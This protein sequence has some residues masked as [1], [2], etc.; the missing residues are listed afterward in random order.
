MTDDP[1]SQFSEA[2]AAAGYVPVKSKIEA[3]DKWH[4]CYINGEKKPHGAYAVKL[5]SNDFAIGQFKDRRS[6]EKTNWHSKTDKKLTAEDRKR[7][8]REQEASRLQR[9]QEDARKYA[10]VSARITKALRGLEKADKHPYLGRKL[11][12]AHG[13]KYRRKGNELIIP[14]Y[15]ADGKIYSVQRI[16]PNGAKFL[17]TGAKKTANY[18]P[19]ASA[20]DDKGIFLVC[21][22]FATGASLRE[23]TGLPVI[24]AF[25][26]GNMRPV[27]ETLK[28]KYP[29]SR[30]VI[31]ADNDAF[32]FDNKKKPEGIEAKEVGGDDPRWPVWAEE[33]RLYNTGIVKAKEAAVAI[34]GATVIWPQFTVS[35]ETKPTDFND[36]HALEGLDV[37]KERVL[38]A[39]PSA[40]GEAGKGEVLE[41]SAEP[42]QPPPPS[43]DYP[44]PEAP[45]SMEGYERDY[46]VEAL[47]EGDYG[48]RFKVLGYN[49]G[50]YYYF[51]YKARQIVALSASSHTLQNFLQLEDLDKWMDKFGAGGE[52]SEKKMALY[53]SNALMQ[54]AIKR[55]VFQEEDR[56]RGCGTWMDAGRVVLHCGDRLYVDG[57]ETAFDKLE[58]EFVYVA[59]ARLM[60]PSNKPLTSEEAYQLRLICE[61]PTWENKI[62]GS[63]LAGWLVVSP[64]SAAL[65]YRPHL[66]LTAEAESG[67]STVLEKI[68][69]PVLGRMSLNVDGGTTEPS[70]REQMGY[71]ARPLVY[72]E[73]E[74]SQNMDAVIKLARLASTGGTVK[75]FGQRIFKARFCALF[76]AINPPISD[77]A[78]ESRTSF[79]VLK[80]N[81]RPTAMQ[82]YEALLDQIDKVIT[83]DFSSRLLART[84]Q[85]MPELMANIKTFQKAARRVI[86]GARASWQIGTLLAGLYLL[87]KTDKISL[88][89]AEEW[90]KKYDWQDHTLSDED[91]DP[92][93]LLQHF[94]SSI[95]RMSTSQGAK[96]LSIGDLILAAHSDGE[97]C[98]E[99]KLLRYY[100]IAV[101]A[102]RVYVANR[103]HNLAKLLSGT[104]WQKKWSRSMADIQGAEK[105]SVFYFSAGNKTSATALPISLFM[106]ERK[107][108]PPPPLYVEEMQEIPF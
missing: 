103:S 85:H 87:S 19:L 68:I 10:R 12:K 83:A 72:D 21:E 64:L 67:K 63:L 35:R 106:E 28:V 38:A 42:D 99:N 59:A 69:K 11:I 18:F 100:G 33:G 44:E 88:E 57:T 80:K 61:A 8:K 77:S 41:P 36:L 46:A 96:E 1:I 15:G 97:N 2:L 39:L 40:A 30:F 7:L 20:D 49:N 89:K 48:L 76:S 60:R 101:K 13:A 14:L 56:V 31:C 71:N 17:W 70:I 102:G 90:I 50:L 32:T 79:I 27:I 58:T 98:A 55:G 81:R 29:A 107:A 66:T 86:K 34:G 104:D 54:L 25:D 53:A 94:S 16:L 9:E 26:A 92:T 43:G 45:D 95:L 51:P 3:D 74:P 52:T 47:P 22:G 84:L 24:V 108:E 75:K 82:E 93:R 91:S 23:A 73:A 5:V 62:S 78:D 6:G 105:I 65:E 37:V 4:A